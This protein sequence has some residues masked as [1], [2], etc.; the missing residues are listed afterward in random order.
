IKFEGITPVITCHL[1]AIP[2]RDHDNYQ[3]VDARLEGESSAKRQ[4]TS[5]YGTYLVG[6][7]SSSQAMDQDQNPSG[8]DH[9]ELLRFYKEDIRKCIKHRDQMRRDEMYVN[10]RPLGSRMDRPE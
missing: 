4:I 3:E 1:S 9:V 2:T 10:G 8:T 5:K 6:E 7:S